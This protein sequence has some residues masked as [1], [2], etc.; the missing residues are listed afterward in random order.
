[1]SRHILLF[2][3]PQLWGRFAFFFYFVLL[4][5]LYAL[6]KPLDMRKKLFEKAHLTTK[7]YFNEHRYACSVLYM[8]V[9]IC[10]TRLH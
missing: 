3:G 9:S 6:K 8:P 7:N 5:V 2:G 10:Y 4:F 1:M